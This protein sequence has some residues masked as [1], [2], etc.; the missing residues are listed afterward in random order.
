MPL[1]RI[2][3]IV[4]DSY[5]SAECLAAVGAAGEHHVRCVEVRRHTSDH[6]DV[7]V[8]RTART[9]HRNER[10]PTQSYPI[11]SAL[12]E[13]ATHV[14]LSDS[15]KRWCLAPILCITGTNAP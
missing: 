9:V 2:D 11:Y 10:L 15:V 3:G 6:V 12:N 1:V 8:S 7:V 13:I 14:H 4:I 5:W